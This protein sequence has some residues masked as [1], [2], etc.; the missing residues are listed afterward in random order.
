MWYVVPPQTDATKMEA[1]NCISLCSFT[2][3]KR[4]SPNPFQHDNAPVPKDSSME[5]WG[6]KAGVGELVWPEQSP[7]L[8]H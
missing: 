1:K 4:S 7:D 5:T 3:L 8:N 2:S 6:D